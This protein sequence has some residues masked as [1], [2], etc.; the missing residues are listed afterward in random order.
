RTADQENEARSLASEAERA[1]AG[2]KASATSAAAADARAAA[3][4]ELERRRKED[5]RKLNMA[6]DQA[7]VAFETG[8][9]SLALQQ[10]E[11]VLELD[12]GN[13]DAYVILVQTKDKF[14]DKRKKEVSDEYREQFMLNRERAD[15]MNIPH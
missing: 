3:E 11:K 8:R 7:R 12:P 2:L 6:L 15:R 10:A 14:Y 9:Y 4:R 1:I 13:P 5:E